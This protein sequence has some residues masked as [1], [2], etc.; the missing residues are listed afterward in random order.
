MVIRFL[1]YTFV[2]FFSWKQISVIIRNI[3]Y[4]QIMSYSLQAECGVAFVGQIKIN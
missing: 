2:S 4:D 3:Y 1:N